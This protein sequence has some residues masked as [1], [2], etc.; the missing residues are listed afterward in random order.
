MTADDADIVQRVVS[1]YA[2]MLDIRPRALAGQQN[3][4]IPELVDAAVSSGIFPEDFDTAQAH[5]LAAVIAGCF[6]AGADYRPDPIDGRVVLIRAADNPMQ[7]DDPLLGWGD[8]ATGGIDLRWVPGTHTTMLR[9]PHASALARLLEDVL[10][11][12]DS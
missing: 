5:R 7:V 8:K 6:A 12:P 11:S 1:M 10:M 9:P 2:D 4:D 3:R